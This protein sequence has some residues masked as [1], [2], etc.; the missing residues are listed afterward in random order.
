MAVGTYYSKRPRSMMGARSSYHFMRMSQRMLLLSIIS[1]VVVTFLYARDA[2]LP[3]SPFGFSDIPRGCPLTPPVDPYIPSTDARFQWG[4]VATNHPVSQILSLSGRRPRKLRRIQHR[5]KPFTDDVLAVRA[6]RRETVKKVFQRCWSSYKAHA[7]MQDELTPVTGQARNPFGAWGATLVD[8][9]D[10]LWIMEMFDDFEEAVNAA[11]NIDFGPNPANLEEVNLFETTIRYLGGFL[12]AYDMTQCSDDRLLDKAFEVGEMIYKAY[13]T[14]NRM[15]VTRWQ[16]NVAAIGED[17]EPPPA[18]LVAELGTAGLELTRLSQ[19]TG[20]MRFYDQAIRLSN[21]FEQQ[22]NKTGLPGLWPIFTDA[23]AADMTVGNDY[24]LGGRSDSAY[25]YLPKMYQ[26]LGGID[27]GQQHKRL[28][29]T[30]IEVAIDK[31]MFRPMLPDGA[32][33]LIP[34]GFHG[35]ATT[36]FADYRGEHLACF[37]GGMLALGGRLFRRPDHIRLGRKVTDGCVWA[38][39]HTRLGVMPELFEMVPCHSRD[40]CEWDPAKYHG[41]VLGDMPEGFVA[42]HDARYILRPEAIES[43]FY[44]YRITGDE[45]YQDIAWEMFSAIERHTRT[46]LA[47]AAIADVNSETAVQIDSM[48]SFWMGE[49]L[50]YFYLMFSDPSVISLDDFVFNTEAHPF[51]RPK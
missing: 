2:F 27:A 4:Y 32:D 47:N 44:M 41:R 51:R 10:T 18:A 39:N 17:Q 31:L 34:T 50:K 33:V 3:G 45:K 38:Y 35:N 28:Y 29:K 13:D 21:L 26:L 49:T 9:L 19:L 37:V 6:Q 20:D 16:P 42:I 1:F 8:S 11:V 24:S 40:D 46:E 23:Q 12:A 22:Q 25:E 48:E 30:A 14:P 7:W 5:F 36:G 43:V 15:P